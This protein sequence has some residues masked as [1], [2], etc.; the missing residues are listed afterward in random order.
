M[1]KTLRWTTIALLLTLPLPG[2]AHA[3]TGAGPADEESSAADLLGAAWGWLTSLL[4]AGEEV[5]TD[6]LNGILLDIGLP[7]LYEGS[8]LDPNGCR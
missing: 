4:G 7:V 5:P 8:H 6:E 1:S 2:T 3:T